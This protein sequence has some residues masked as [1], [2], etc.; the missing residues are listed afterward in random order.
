VEFEWDEKK[1]HANIIKHGVDF[2]DAASLFS[3]PFLILEDSR[4]DY[5]EKRF[6][7]FGRIE[8]RHIVLTFTKR[9]EKIRIISMRK[10][11]K[12]E[13]EKFNKTIIDRMGKS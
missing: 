1:R 5:G 13:Q 7:A 9:E 10:A 3:R 4:H 8:N 2:V 11:N 12:R 6:V